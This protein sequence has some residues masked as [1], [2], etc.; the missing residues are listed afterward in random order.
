M[1][2]RSL[3]PA[4]AKEVQSLIDAGLQAAHKSEVPRQ[5]LGGSR[6]GHP[7]AR[8]LQY[9]YLNSPKDEGRGFTGQ[10]LRIFAIGHALEDLAASWLRSAGFELLTRQS[11]DP[12]APQLGFSVAGER[13]QGHVDGIVISAPS[14]LLVACP[15]LWECKTMNAQSWRR[16]VKEGVARAKP[17]YA[18][19]IAI[20]Q[21][22][23]APHVPG[24]IQNPALFTAI[25]KDTGEL[26]HEAVSFD[27][28]LAQQISDRGVQILR[29]TDAGEWLPR[30]ARSADF[31][32]CRL[33]PWAK[34]CWSA[35][36]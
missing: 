33:C 8:A 30:L 3:L 16:C 5:Y 26:Y 2:A 7:C 32:E 36:S 31:Y 35:P 12:E 10:T 14:G 24:L 17:I 1:G 6:L 22:Y 29:A 19:Q 21:A 20:Y 11:N 4:F 15:A 27:A 25:N 23:M 9:E 34:R 13:I 28:G 18:A